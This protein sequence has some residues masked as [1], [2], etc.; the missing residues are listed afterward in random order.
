MKDKAT[1]MKRVKSSPDRDDIEN[2][3]ICE[4]CKRKKAMWNGK[5]Q[6]I[7]DGKEFSY[8]MCDTCRQA[9]QTGFSMGEMVEYDRYKVEVNYGTDQ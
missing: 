4:F 7:Q 5:H 3:P 9:Y 6:R 1:Y 8:L 2:K